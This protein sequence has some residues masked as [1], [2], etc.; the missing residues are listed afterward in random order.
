MELY[1]FVL[2]VVPS[3]KQWEKD[4]QA[5]W[6]PMRRGKDKEAKHQVRMGVGE[7][8]LYKLMFPKDQLNNVMGLIGEDPGYVEKYPEVAS[9]VS[10]IRKLLKL[11]EAPK[12]TR[13]FPHMMPNKFNKAVAV[14]PIGTREDEVGDDGSEN[15]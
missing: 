5:V 8:K 13:I 15:I 2:G 9:K 10:W 6:L 11:K 14:I 4:L 3:I 1:T 7:V 12:P